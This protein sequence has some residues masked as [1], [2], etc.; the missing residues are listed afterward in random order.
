MLPT[1]RSL[2]IGLILPTGYFARGSVGLEFGPLWGVALLLSVARLLVHQVT[3]RLA[4]SVSVQIVEEELKADLVLFDRGASA[5]GH[6]DIG[7][8]PEG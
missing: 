5:R 3:E 1:G 4:G 6:D 7:T 2:G 8:L